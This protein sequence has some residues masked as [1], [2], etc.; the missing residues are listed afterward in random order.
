MMKR[1]KTRSPAAVKIVGTSLLLVL[2]A[3]TAPIIQRITDTEE[4]Y[5]K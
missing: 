2:N 5:M 1:K 3:T 4:K